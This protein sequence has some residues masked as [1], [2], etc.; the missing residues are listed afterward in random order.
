MSGSFSSA[1]AASSGERP[2]R[3]RPRLKAASSSGLNVVSRPAMVVII[4][5]TLA[6]SRAA[7]GISGGDSS[8]EGSVRVPLRSK[9]THIAGILSGVTAIG[10][11]PGPAGLPGVGN[12][13]QLRPERLHLMIEKWGRRYGPVFR[14][15]MGPRE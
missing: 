11:L 9:K 6:S 4:A 13:L 1:P 3:A 15:S 2:A 8:T 14:F 12:A 7:I 10:D 5:I